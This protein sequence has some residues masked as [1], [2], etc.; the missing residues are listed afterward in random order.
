MVIHLFHFCLWSSEKNTGNLNGDKGFAFCLLVLLQKPKCLAEMH[1]IAISGHCGTRSSWTCLSLWLTL[2]KDNFKSFAANIIFFSVWAFAQ[3]SLNFLLLNQGCVCH[4]CLAP[5]SV[6][7][8]H[9]VTK[10][11]YNMGSTQEY[12]IFHFCGILWNCRTGVLLDAE[13]K[14]V[15]ICPFSLF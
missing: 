9:L 7:I 3:P 2:H 13:Y 5:L 14:S 10:L 1:V 12:I 6:S 4:R 15:I 11:P 8:K